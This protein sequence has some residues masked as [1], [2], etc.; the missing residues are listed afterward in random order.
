LSDTIRNFVPDEDFQAAADKAIDNFLEDFEKA[1]GQSM[2]DTLISQA[3]F[4]LWTLRRLRALGHAIDA[5]GAAPEADRG[6]DSRMNKDYRLFSLW[7]QFHMD[8]TLTALYT[9]KDIPVPVQ[10]SICDGLRSAVNAYAIGEE[11]LALRS[12]V[13]TSEPDDVPYVWDEE[14]E[15][16]LSSSMRDLDADLAAD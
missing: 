11:A 15:E 10:S 9:K 2:T 1:R 4:T 16:L 5:A 7:S 13:Q 8:V 12:P 3:Q 14:D 6:A